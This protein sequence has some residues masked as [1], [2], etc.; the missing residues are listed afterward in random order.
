M[1]LQEDMLFDN[2]YRL[3]KV[4]GCGGFSEVWL[5]ED[6]KVGNKKMALKVYA[7]GSGLDEDGVQ[8]FSSEFELVFD[9][10][11]TNL[12][13][14]SYFSVCER[15]PYLLM[16]FSELGSVS[17]YVGQMT[18]EDAWRFLHDV[19]A[20][21]SYLHAQEPTIIHQDIKPDNVLQ[22]H[23][24]NYQITDFGISTKVRST[25]RKSMSSN[26]KSAGTMA[27]MPPERFGKDNLPIMAS[28][29]WAVGATVFELLT[30]DMPFGEHGGLIQKSGA[31]IPTLRGQWSDE[32]QEVIARCLQ[33]EP[34]NRPVAKQLVEWTESHMKGEKISFDVLVE[35]QEEPAKPSSNVNTKKIIG[36]IAGLVAVLVLIFGVVW[37]FK[38][39]DSDRTTAVV[40]HTEPRTETKVVVA[41]PPVQQALAWL[42]VYSQILTD[43]LTAFQSGDFEKAKKE[44][45]TA[46]DLVVRNQDNSGKE[47]AV[48]AFIATCDQKIEEKAKAAEP[49]PAPAATAT[50][51]TPPPPWIAEYDRIVRGAQAA[52]A[53]KDYAKAKTEY[54][55]ALNIATQN[56]DQKKISFVNQK[57]ADCNKVAEAP[58][59]SEKP[60][61]QEEVDKRLAAYNF[62]GNFALGS[63]YMVVQRKSDNRW[64]IIDKQGNEV[65]PATYNQVS[66][67]LK[68][69]Y[70]ALKN[71]KGWVVFDTSLKKVATGLSGL[72][73]YQ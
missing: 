29:I 35:K 38:S 19:A 57:I 5:V 22:D 70:Y 72:T 60:V 15:S 68:N 73:E 51:A 25:L 17:K 4:L 33:K 48:K 20:G 21:L 18:E 40:K 8:L 10:N 63:S 71:D 69:G 55:K 65:E 34:W 66:V 44:Y 61:S 56:N 54:T 39:G 36:G 41:E 30:G 23:L 42:D 49:A 6:T 53:S 32:L 46:L 3:V 14:P 62:V 47:A 67:R 28:D 9:L 2:R 50:P 58:K 37:F 7:P 59:A 52:Y 43:A 31:E 27:Y 45:Q 24:G 26:V 11:H 12:L 64:G 1:N 13:R 16:P